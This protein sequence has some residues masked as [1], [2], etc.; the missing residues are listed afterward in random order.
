MV[1]YVI[2]KEKAEENIK[3]EGDRTESDYVPT[4]IKL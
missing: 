3:G 1:D 2:A 4:E